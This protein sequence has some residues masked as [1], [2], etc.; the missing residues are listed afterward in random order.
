MSD[1][2][3]AEARIADPGTFPLLWALGEEWSTAMR[4]VYRRVVIRGEPWFTRGKGGVRSELIARGWSQREATSML[5]AARGAQDAAVEATKLSLE[6]SREQLV[7]TATQLAKAQ[8][9]TSKKA[10]DKRH[11]LASRRSRLICR[12]QKLEERLGSGG[13]RVCFGSARLA[14]AGSRPKSH[15]YLSHQEWREVWERARAGQWFCQGDVGFPGG[16]PSAR[17][18]LSDDGKADALRLRIP[19]VGKLRE[20]SGGAESVEIRLDGFC[21]GRERNRNKAARRSGL[22]RVLEPSESAAAARLR[23]QLDTSA[24]TSGSAA[25]VRRP[26]STPYKA[27]LASGPVSVRVF[28]R[29]RTRHRVEDQARAPGRPAAPP[30]ALP[31]VERNPEELPER[32]CR[33]QDR[34]CQ[35]V[36]IH[37]DLSQ[38]PDQR[39][40]H[41]AAPPVPEMWVHLPP[42]RRGR[43]QR[44]PEGD[45]FGARPVRPDT[46]IRVTHP[47]AVELWSPDQRQ[48]P[49]LVHGREARA[50]RVA[51]DRALPQAIAAGESDPV[52]SSTG[53]PVPARSVGCGGVSRAMARNHGPAKGE[54]EAPSVRAGRFT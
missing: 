20:L 40:L 2:V 18:R 46:K 26:P 31:L 5:V 29:E 1:Q 14:R 25:S 30:A 54:P 22:A 28:W 21:S 52:N 41:G 47:G 17:I 39:P 35:R 15:D 12:C 43:H 38:M 27:R 45:R 10:V 16:N 9:G 44:P 32:E 3:T 4:E 6:R 50:L 36:R 37:Q 24:W 13:V 34:T 48:A 7:E 19:A 51:P 53:A 23:W 11:G 8:R 42:R 49:R 33:G